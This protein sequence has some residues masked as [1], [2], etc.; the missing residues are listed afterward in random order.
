[1]RRLALFAFLVAGA[2]PLFAAELQVGPGQTYADPAAA[3]K[4][5]K[6]GD[7]IV[8]HARPGGYG[9][10]ALNVTKPK[11][12]IRAADE[13]KRVHLDGDGYDY[14][15]R[16][17]VPRA[18]VQFSPGADGG[19]IEGFELTGAHNESGNG[20]GVRINQAN[21]VAVRNC[22]I[23]DCD[24]GIMSNGNGTDATAKNQRIEACVIHANGTK[25]NAGYNHN[26]YLGG[27]SATLL[28]CEIY[29]SLTGHNLKSRAHLIEVR[30]C[31]IHD[32]ANREIDLVD[33][34][35]DTDRPG[36]DALIVDSRIVKSPT[37]A[38]NRGVIHFGKD[39]KSTRDGTLT[40]RD[41]EI[42]TPFVTP[43][44]TL[45]TP[46]TMAVLEHDT[47]WEGGHRQSNQVLLAATEAD[48]PHRLTGSDNWLGGGFAHS[49]LGGLTHT[50]IANAGEKP[51]TQPSRTIGGR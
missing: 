43:V 31:F 23:H 7:V 13:S 3:L 42:V 22:D 35:G 14:S 26:L 19:V 25:V 17:P 20:A 15:G 46:Q 8:V 33:D 45:D 11:I 36:S 47:I 4:A 29:G 38:G 27:T 51:A 44:I 50:Y 1:M 41:C 39:G 6:A 2:T 9:K 32:S 16:G 40:I 10:V 24:M 34:K 30:E 28:R 21:D 49:P 5:A 18:I 37:C 12:T 48:L